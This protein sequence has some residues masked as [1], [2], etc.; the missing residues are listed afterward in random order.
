MVS[1]ISLLS[2]IP[3]ARHQATAVLW[4]HMNISILFGRLF[5]I[6]SFDYGFSGYRLH[7][8]GVRSSVLIYHRRYRACSVFLKKEN[9][10][11]VKSRHSPFNPGNVI[12]SIGSKFWFQEWN[13][14]ASSERRILIF[15]LK[16]NRLRVKSDFFFFFQEKSDIDIWNLFH[17]RIFIDIWIYR[18]KYTVG[19]NINL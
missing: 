13:K 3:S 4:F 19:K 16:R 11:F 18:C 6:H 12:W 9:I 15:L 14:T 5:D 2:I 1:W 17:S 10:D 8:G 7:W